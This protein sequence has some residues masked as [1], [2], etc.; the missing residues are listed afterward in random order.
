MTSRHERGFLHRYFL[1][2]SSKRMH[3]WIHYFDIYERHFSRFCNSAPVILEIGVFGGGSLAMWKEYFGAGAKVLGLDINPE[4]KQHEGDGVEIF[5][6]SQDDPAVIE[7][8]LSRHPRIDIVLDDGSH[9]MRHMIASF[10]LLYERIHARG[11]Y[12]VED[13][14]T[15]YWDEYG[16]G[17][18]RQGSFIEYAKGKI[19]EIN[20]VH[21]RGV[22]PISSFTR[23]TDCISIYD[24]IIV[25]EK[26]SQGSRQAPVTG[27]L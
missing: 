12:M 10:E 18:G 21:A 11:V 5:I 1:G 25:F 9:M 17:L 8:I 3:K 26:R 7:D 14:H 19:D 24:S 23:I 2:N 6:G 16:G 20:A 13:T 15:C 27:P 22:L 4:C